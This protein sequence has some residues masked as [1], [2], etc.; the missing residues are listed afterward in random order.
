LEFCREFFCIFFGEFLGCAKGEEK[1]WEEV[2]FVGGKEEGMSGGVEAG[3]S[4]S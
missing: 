1:R 4:V 2:D 3:V